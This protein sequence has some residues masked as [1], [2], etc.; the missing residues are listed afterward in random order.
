VP[1]ESDRLAEVVAYYVGELSGDRAEDAWHSLVELGPDAL[2]HVIASFQ[3]TEDLSV[4]AALLTVV[5]EY[6]SPDAIPFLSACF[7]DGEVEIWKGAL[8]AFVT[9]AGNAAAGALREA[10]RTA[11]DEKREWIDDALEQVSERES[12]HSRST[13][14]LRPMASEV[15]VT[16]IDLAERFFKGQDRLKGLLPPEV[17]AAS[18]RAEIVG[19]PP[20]DAAGHGAFGQAFYAGFPDIA[21]TIDEVRPT[22]TGV[23]VRFTLR[24]TH[25]APFMG[26]PPTNR[27][28]V[29]S[30]MV[31]MTVV[32]EQ[33]T[34]L[35]GLFD[36]LGLLRQI[37]AVPT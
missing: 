10:R 15:T 1:P 18:Y 30:A 32:D 2:S 37:D 6:R 17:V 3:Q 11:S 12:I 34:H 8:D 19:F 24:G 33:V 20:M 21:H 7:D 26:I 29:V 23:A 31:L 13:D 9:L 35:H 16:G 5:R 28:I 25:T 4:R 22:D 27:S 36:Q 14:V